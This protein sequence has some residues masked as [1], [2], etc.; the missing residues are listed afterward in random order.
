VLERELIL[1]FEQDNKDQESIR[2]HPGK[3]V[4]SKQ[5]PMKKLHTFNIENKN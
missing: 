2:W 4:C 3:R 1:I 5:K